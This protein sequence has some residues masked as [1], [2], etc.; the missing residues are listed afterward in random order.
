VGPRDGLDAVE[1]RKILPCRESNPGRPA[2]SPSLYRLNHP[3]S[4]N[5]IK[6]KN[7]NLEHQVLL[8]YVTKLNYS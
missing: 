5:W 6:F 1:E 2:R 8:K 3:D 4:L 7:K